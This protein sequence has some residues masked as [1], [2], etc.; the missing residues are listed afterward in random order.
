MSLGK[1]FC[2]RPGKMKNDLTAFESEYIIPDDDDHRGFCMKGSIRTKQRCPECGDSFTHSKHGLICGKCNRVPTRLFVDIYHGKRLR[3][4]RDRAGELLDSYQRAHRLLEVIRNEIDRC[5]FDPAN[6]EPDKVR[7]NYFYRRAD[8]YLDYKQRQY[9]Q[10]GLAPSSLRDIKGHFRNH[11]SPFFK[12]IDVR[13]IRTGHINRFHRSL[14]EKLA[15]KTHKNIMT[16]LHAFIRHLYRE[17]YIVRM[18]EF[19]KISP[20]DPKWR[21]CDVDV[22]LLIYNEIPDRHKPIFLFMMRQGVRP[23]EARALK[24]ENVDLKSGAV[25]ICAVFS[26][27]EY[28]PYTKNRRS[29]IIP[30]HSEVQKMLEGMPVPLRGDQY[31]FTNR[32]GGFYKHHNLRKIWNRARKNAGHDKVRLYDATRHSVASQAVNRGVPLHVIGELLG[33]SSS[34]MTKRYAHLKIDALRAAVETMAPAGPQKKKG[35]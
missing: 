4:Y 32:S 22:Q 31:V 25:T 27:D 28:K 33:H 14:S 5:V 7:A 6:Y 9:E 26:M 8:D 35:R 15:Q 30:L 1:G 12:N 11:I 24:W 17:E 16:T 13:D 19:P 20:P 3:I 2:L 21:W 10:G 23:G 34:E 18:P 29:R